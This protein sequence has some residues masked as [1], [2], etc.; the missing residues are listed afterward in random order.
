MVES[1]PQLNKHHQTAARR[2]AEEA[3]G[4]AV[5]QSIQRPPSEL[6]KDDSTATSQ[7]R[8]WERWP[9]RLWQDCRGAAT[10]DYVLLI[11]VIA[12]P[13]I[14]ILRMTLNGLVAYYG[15]MASL[16]ALPMP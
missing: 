2:T 10:M 8:L 4:P 6:P 12:I 16:N 14:L 9:S 13:S 3:D 5:E 1:R 7:T 15:M 11:G